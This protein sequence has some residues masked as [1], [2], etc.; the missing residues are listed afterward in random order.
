MDKPSGEP[1]AELAKKRFEEWAASYSATLLISSKARTAFEA[2]KAGW[3]AASPTPELLEQAA[4]QI[5]EDIIISEFCPDAEAY[6][7]VLKILQSILG[8]AEVHK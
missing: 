1:F 6:K 2:Y 5:A 3:Q 4:R 8:G 7:V